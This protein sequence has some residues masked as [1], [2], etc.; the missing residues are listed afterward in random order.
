MSGSGFSEEIMLEQKARVGCQSNNN[1][2]RSRGASRIVGAMTVRRL[3]HLLSFLLLAGM[4]SS[5]TP[6]GFAT[7]ALAQDQ[8]GGSMQCLRSELKRDLA[9]EP[10]AYASIG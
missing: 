9:R 5:L 8:G 1:S 6:S 10:E 2:S 4:V 3:P 7:P